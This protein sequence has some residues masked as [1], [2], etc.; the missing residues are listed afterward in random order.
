MINFRMGPSLM[1]QFLISTLRRLR[2]ENCHEFETSLC[3]TAY[4]RQPRLQGDSLSQRKQIKKTKEAKLSQKG[5]IIF[6]GNIFPN[7]I[8]NHS[9][10]QIHKNHQTNKITTQYKKFKLSSML[11][12]TGLIHST[13]NKEKGAER[14]LSS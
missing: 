14:W 6:Q 3:Y 11:E 13:A 10:N 12:N 2:Q 1:S 4:A 8:L 5:N 9:K 7:Y